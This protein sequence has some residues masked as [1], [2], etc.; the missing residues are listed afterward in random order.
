MLLEDGLGEQERAGKALG[1]LV[2]AGTGS[3]PTQSQPTQ[4]PA[5]GT[6][7]GGRGTGDHSISM[8]GRARATMYGRARARGG[9]ADGLGSQEGQT[10]RGGRFYYDS[11]RGTSPELGR[12]PGEAEGRESFGTEQYDR[13]VE[14]RFLSAAEHPLSTFSVDVDTASYANVRRFLNQGRLPPPDA[15]RIE[16]MVNYFRYDYPLPEGSDPIAVD[17]EVV[18]CPWNGKHRLLRIGI[19]AE[20][21]DRDQRGPSNL[22]TVAKDVKIQ[23]ELNPVEVARYRL[24]GYENRAMPD[25]HFDNDKKDAGEIGAG[26]AVTALYELVPAEDEPQ[27][28]AS[29]EGLRYQRG[30]QRELTEAARSGELLTVRLR[31]KMPDA[32]ASKLLELTVRDAGKRFGEASADFRFAAAVA[33]FGM[34]LRGSEHSGGAT[35]GAVEEF[36]VSA[37]GEDPGGWRAEFLDLVH[38][39]GQLQSR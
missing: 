35:L 15:V 20:Q 24:I 34:L 32:G 12:V 2:P 7:A 23:I 37:L 30:A 16:E 27:A 33:A 8:D 1:Q 17:M 19:Q 22:V 25:R 38:R 3:Q 5:E 36:T 29:V 6:L 28:G 4:V 18:Q 26:H 39:A 9:G 21:I 13:I 11:R 10:I 14:N 31:Y